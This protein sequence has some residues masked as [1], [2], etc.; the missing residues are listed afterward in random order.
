MED[1]KKRYADYLRNYCPELYVG[2]DHAAWRDQWRHPD[3][4][5]L[6]LRR[7]TAGSGRESAEIY[8]PVMRGLYGADVL[9]ART[10]GVYF[11]RLFTQ[12]AQLT[13]QVLWAIRVCT[14]AVIPLGVQYEIV[15]GFT[16]IGQVK[17]ALT[18]SFFPEANVF[19]PHFCDSP[20]LGS[21]NGILCRAYF[22]YFRADGFCSSV[23]VCDETHFRKAQT[24]TS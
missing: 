1:R 11:V 24:G 9:A 22:R 18:L 12:D 6:Q 10:V 2:G 13:E 4:I 20:F 7:K 17:L 8:Y 21:G 16:A 14:L 3:D 5:G 19:C 15:D 23:F